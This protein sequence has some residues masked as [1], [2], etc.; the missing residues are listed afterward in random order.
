MNKFLPFFMLFFLNLTSIYTQNCVQ[1]LRFTWEGDTTGNKAVW[2]VNDQLNIYKVGTVDITVSLEDPFNVN[3][4]TFNPS[5]FNDYTKSNAYYGPGS[6]MLQATSTTVN[7]PLCIHFAFSSPVII[8]DFEVFDIDFIARGRPESSFQDSVSFRSSMNSR[9][10]PLVL[11]NMHL[12]PYFTTNGQTV[13]SKHIINSNGD[14]SFTDLRGAVKVH[15]NNA[16][17]NKFTMCYSN[18][19][20]DDGVSN[21]HAIRMVG[22]DFCKAGVGSLGGIVKEQLTNNPLGGSEIKLIDTFGLPVLNHIE[23]VFTMVTGPDGLYYFEDVPFGIYDVIQVND[24]VGYHSVS[25]NDGGN[26]NTIRVT[27][28]INNPI[29]LGNDFIEG[30]GPLPVEFEGMKV[31]WEDNNSVDIEWATLAEWNNS[32]FTVLSS[33]DGQSFSPVVRINSLGNSN[34]RT[35]YNYLD[36][37]DPSIQLMYYKLIQTD[38]DGRIKELSVAFLKRS[39]QEVQYTVYPNPS[40]DYI[41]VQGLNQTEEIMTYMILDQGGKLIKSGITTPGQIFISDL[42]QGTYFLRIHVAGQNVVL[43]FQKW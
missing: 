1:S 8:Q 32:Y 3:T 22:F 37:I 41:N 30:F 12:F 16:A 33:R 28:D 20:M 7:Q 19:S 18:A 43:P 36:K 25:D 35:E 11:E 13:R 21:S 34:S 38:L 40:F 29:S 26:D 24:P 5:E 27:I 10:V 42:S 15:S 23:D 17:V 31:S 39:A 14:I 6:L 9:N 4:T 2:N